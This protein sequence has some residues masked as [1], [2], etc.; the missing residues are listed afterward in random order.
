M[1]VEC[2]SI[3][4]AEGSPT[5]GEELPWYKSARAALTTP[6]PCETLR[7]ENER[8]KEQIESLRSQMDEMHTQAVEAIRTRTLAQEASTRDLEELRRANRNNRERNLA[9]D[10]L[11]YVWCSGGCEGGIHRFG[12]HPALTEE[13]VRAAVANTRRLVLWFNNAGDKQ[14]DNVEIKTRWET[15]QK[16]RA[17]LER[18]KINLG[19]WR[20]SWSAA[21]EAKREA[22]VELAWKQAGWADELVRVTGKL[23]AD[24]ARALE[25]LEPFA[26]A[27]AHML[28]PGG[29][30]PMHVPREFWECAAALLAE[31]KERK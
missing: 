17:D 2:A 18:L 29:Y 5:K 28:G 19:T 3:D 23:R 10:A 13:I 7:E 27:G 20:I 8:L 26:V 12:E 16:L 11:H 14:L 9:L 31:H 25:A 4:V 1:T 6:C 21:V 15:D 22:E 30:Y 24:I